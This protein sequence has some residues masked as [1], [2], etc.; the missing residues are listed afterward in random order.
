MRIIRAIVIAIRLRA[1]VILV[2]FG[3]IFIG[4]HLMMLLMVRHGLV[5]LGTVWAHEFGI[6]IEVPLGFGQWLRILV[7]VLLQLIVEVGRRHGVPLA[8]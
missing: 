2:T 5:V 3:T 4:V 7:Q 6:A 1:I 8:M